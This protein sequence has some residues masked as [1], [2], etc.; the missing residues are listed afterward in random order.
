ML[1]CPATL[2]GRFSMEAEMKRFALFACA[3]LVVL[4]SIE[5]AEAQFRYRHGYHARG[6]GSHYYGYRRGLGRGWRSRGRSDRWMGPGRD[7]ECSCSATNYGP[8]ARTTE[9]VDALRRISRRRK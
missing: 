1:D 9:R 2:N 8:S 7:R 4:G 3:S 5:S 6:L